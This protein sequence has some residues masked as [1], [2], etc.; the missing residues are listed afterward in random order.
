MAPLSSSPALCMALAVDAA[1][2]AP[3]CGAGAAYQRAGQCVVERGDVCL[4]CWLRVL[5]DGQTTRLAATYPLPPSARKKSK[6][7]K[8]KP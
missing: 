5:G 3:G 2:G 7:C 4:W 6:K 8:N 1:A